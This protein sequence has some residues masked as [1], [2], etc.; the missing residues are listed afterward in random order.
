MFHAPKSLLFDG[1]DQFA[2]ADQRRGG[3]T[4]KCV[5]AKDDQS[6]LASMNGRDVN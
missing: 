1:R 3:V 2:V 6:V 4:V 5:K